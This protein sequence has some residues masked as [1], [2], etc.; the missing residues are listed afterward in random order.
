[1][2]FCKVDNANIYYEDYGSGT[3]IVMI[4]GFTPDHRLMKG[5]ME[6]VFQ[7]FDGYR[8]LYID[9]PGMGRTK[10]Y[11]QIRN[12]D[13]MLKAVIQFI[14]AMLPNQP[15]LIAGESYGGYLT[16]G[17]IAK[18]PDR[19]LGAAFIC[20][21]VI[22]NHI[23]RTLPK[24]A[25]LHVDPEFVA[26][27]TK[28]EAEEFGS[29]HVVMDEY[30]WKRF[31]E[32]IIAGMKLADGEF[33]EKLSRNYGFSFDID[34]AEFPEPSLFLVGRQD[35][36]TGYHDVYEL[37]EKYPRATFSTLDLAGH[38]LQI[39]QPDLFNAH[40]EDWLQRVKLHQSVQKVEK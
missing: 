19:I 33:L 9:L 8:R 1:M 6:P 21:M 7:E 17:V 23:D 15:F 40:I 5:C 13:G 38:N 24:Q 28:E 12:T 16:R 26:T 35:H 27:L 10:D 30:N 3:P 14:N 32:E 2:P 31:N 22:P 11:E 37:L 39:E 20:P 18:M 25:H 4:H 29:M 36:I 34:Q